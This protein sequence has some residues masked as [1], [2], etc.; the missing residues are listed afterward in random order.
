MRLV[1]EELRLVPGL[2]FL[3][4]RT[5]LGKV[6]HPSGVEVGSTTPLEPLLGSV[7]VYNMVLLQF[8]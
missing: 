1:G 5:P 8:Y 7:G 4:S 2:S 3:I 6:S